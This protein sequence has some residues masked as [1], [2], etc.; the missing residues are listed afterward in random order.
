MKQ[1]NRWKMLAGIALLSLSSC[2]VWAQAPDGPPPG[3]PPDQAGQPGPERGP[4]PERQLKQLTKL[5]SLTPDQQ[6]GV[7]AV[8]EQ[9]AT[10]MKA[11]RAKQDPASQGSET[12][13]SRR[14]LMEQ[15]RQIHEE[16]NTKINA[17]LDENQ[18]K[19]FADWNAKREERMR[20]HRNGGDQGSEPPPP[21]PPPA[22]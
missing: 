18:K 1:F 6:I 3:P 11:L 8:L 19:A 16:T 21:P 12:R 10:E 5:L 13:E 20:N 15:G 4:N 9:S 17:L 2:A 14:A 7:K 22:E